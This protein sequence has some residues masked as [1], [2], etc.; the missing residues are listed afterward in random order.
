MLVEN[1]QKNSE[2]SQDQIR[3]FGFELVEEF[4]ANRLKNLFDY[5]LMLTLLLDHPF[6]SLSCSLA[7]CFRKNRVFERFKFKRFIK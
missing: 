2:K 6:T 5:N 1:L 3:K 7:G 4:V